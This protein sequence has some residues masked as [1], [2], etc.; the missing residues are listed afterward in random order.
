MG[1][2]DYYEIDTLEIEEDKDCERV[3][4]WKNEEEEEPRLQETRR[5]VIRGARGEEK[6]RQQE[7]QILELMIEG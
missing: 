3:R 4:Q 1:A 7:K 6:S 2:R 5:R